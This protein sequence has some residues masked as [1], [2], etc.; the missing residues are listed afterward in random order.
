MPRETF[1]HKATT[2][3]PRIEVWQAL[4]RPATWEGIAGVDRVIDPTIDEAGRLRGFMFETMVAGQPYR[5]T[6][7]EQRRI[8]GETMAWRIE[9][10]E[11]KGAITVA[12]ADIDDGTEIQVTIE[13]ASA[14]MLSAMF[15][16]VIAGTLRHGFPDSVN[17]FAASL[18]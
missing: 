7:T 5:G 9:S 16:P 3:T 13:V 10:S 6:A 17:Q 18:G 11:L 12:L 15:F 4:D 1:T 2:A 14:G 8:E